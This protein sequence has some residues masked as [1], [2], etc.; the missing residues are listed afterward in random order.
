MCQ[1]TCSHKIQNN[2][3]YV[4]VLLFLIAPL[5]CTILLPTRIPG[6]RDVLSDSLVEL[7][8]EHASICFSCHISRKKSDFSMIYHLVSYII[9]NILA[10]YLDLLPSATAIIQQHRRHTTNCT[11]ATHVTRSHTIKRG[12]GLPRQILQTLQYRAS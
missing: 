10:H 2:C 5:F 1:G 3:V 12:T 6:S 9:K 4:V 11:I 7:R 8:K